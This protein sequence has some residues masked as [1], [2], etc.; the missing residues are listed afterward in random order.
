[1]TKEERQQKFLKEHPSFTYESKHKFYGISDRKYKHDGVL[2]GRDL[3]R[4]LVRKRDKHTCQRCK[5]KWIKGKRRFDVHHLN[6]LCGKRSKKYDKVSKIGGLL[7]LCHK[8]HFHH[9][10]HSFN[11]TKP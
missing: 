3:I 7:T 11:L 5:K 6:G 4:E 8:C 9:P 1:M 2:Q 10:E